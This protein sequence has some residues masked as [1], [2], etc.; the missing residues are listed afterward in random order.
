MPDFLCKD[1]YR[2]GERQGG[3]I[4]AKLEATL[5]AACRRVKFPIGNLVEVACTLF[6]RERFDAASARNAGTLRERRHHSFTLAISIRLSHWQSA[7]NLSGP[8]AWRKSIESRSC[9]LWVISGRWGQLKECPLYLQKQTSPSYFAMSAF[10]DCLGRAGWGKK[11]DIRAHAQRSFYRF[12][13]PATLRL[14]KRKNRLW[15][16]KS[17][18]IWLWRC[19]SGSTVTPFPHSTHNDEGSG[20]GCLR[21]GLE[22]LSDQFRR[23]LHRLTA[24][25]SRR[26]PSR[27]PWAIGCLRLHLRHCRCYWALHWP[28]PNNFETAEQARAMS[29]RWIPAVCWPRRSWARRWRH[30]A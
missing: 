19:L 30:R 5:D 14:L 10:P 28:V 3:A 16:G 18:R 17:Q 24:R 29:D 12:G 8:N 13:H 21:A 25:L 1:A 27:T 20:L 6:A 22:Y 4:V 7:P 2:V 26:T 9:P 11:F 15:T 23:R